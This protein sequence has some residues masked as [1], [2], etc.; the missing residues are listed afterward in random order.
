MTSVL[1]GH[2]VR[3][4]ANPLHWKFPARLRKMRKAKGLSASALGL[5]AGLSKNSAILLDRAE[6]CPRVNTAEKLARVLGVSPAWLAFGLGEAAASGEQGPLRCEGLAAR[7]M[8]ARNARRLSVRETD[9]MAGNAEGVVKS[10]E[11]GGM[12]ALDTLEAL[13]K[14]LGVSP[15]W[16]AFGEGQQ[17]MPMRRSRLSEQHSTL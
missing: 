4:R 14:A 16:L 2:V 7:A 17:E 8:E 1:P 11:H 3:G 13:A 5:A 6:K 9:R 12:P 15:A 10:I